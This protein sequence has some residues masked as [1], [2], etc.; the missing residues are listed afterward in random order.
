MLGDI[1]DYLKAT[2]GE[3][4]HHPLQAAGAALGVP[5]YDPFFGGLFNNHEGGALLSPTGNFSSSAWKEM[6]KDNPNS[7]GGLDLFHH[8]NSIADVVAPM[9]AGGYGIGAAGGGS[10]LFGMGGSSGAGADGLTGF[11]S[12]PAAFGDSGLTSVVSPSGSGLSAMMGGDLSGALGDAPVGLFSGLLPGGGMSGTA[13][14]ALG[15]GLS[16]GVA[17]MAPLGGASMGGFDMG[18]LAQ[19]ASRLLQQQSQQSQ[20]RGQQA[21]GNSTFSGGYANPQTPIFAPRTATPTVNPQLLG[22]LMIA[23]RLGAAGGY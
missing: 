5:G 10:G 8:V 19:L 15:G 7:T 6:Y 9:I 18:G 2:I 22:Q 4:G 1:G 3:I 11:F 13:S 17:G 14:G 20:Q 12:G 23:D 21:S 16:G